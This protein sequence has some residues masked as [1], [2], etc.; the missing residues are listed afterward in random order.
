MKRIMTPEQKYYY[1]KHRMEEIHGWLSNLLFVKEHPDHVT[2][3][4]Y[5]LQLDSVIEEGIDA[6]EL[7]LKD[8][9]DDSIC[10]ASCKLGMYWCSL[11]KGHKEN[12]SMRGW[13]TWVDNFC[14]KWEE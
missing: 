13:L 12:H 8:A 4:P 3:K 14:D 9:E 5:L 6:V 7:S 10:H 2:S 11:K 1:L